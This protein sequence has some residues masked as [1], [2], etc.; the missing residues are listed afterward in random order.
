[1]TKH[2]IHSQEALDT[3]NALEGKVRKY[4]FTSSQ[5]VYDFGVNHKEEDFNP[6]EYQPIFKGQKRV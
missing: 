4:V 2:V 5:A 6:L 3:L 1:M